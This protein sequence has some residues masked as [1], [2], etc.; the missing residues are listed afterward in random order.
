MSAVGNYE[1]IDAEFGPYNG[2]STG[3]EQSYTWVAPAGK[4][5][6]S[7]THR[8]SNGVVVTQSNILAQLSLD[9]TTLEVR[10]KY[11]WSGQ[12]ARFVFRVVVAEMGC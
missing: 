10:G 1:I 9:G 6:L 4:K 12:E 11:G 7:A 5:V 3:V 8:S 2:N